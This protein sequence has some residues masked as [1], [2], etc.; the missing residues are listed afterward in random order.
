MDQSV[1]RD[2][3]FARR[4]VGELVGPYRL[5]QVLGVGGMAAV[6]LGR[7]HDG[8]VA[9]IK[10]L[11]PAMSVRP[12]VRERFYR[13]GYVANSIQHPGVVRVLSHGEAQHAYLAMELLSGETLSERARRLGQLPLPE[14]LAL[15][16]QVLDVLCVAHERGIVHRDLKPDNLFVTSAN[17]IKILDFGLARLS[18]SA[19]SEHRTRTGVALG[20]LP[21]MAPEQALGRLSEIDG[22]V[23]LFALGATLF[24]ILT[25]RRVHEGNSVAELLIAMASK[26]APPLASVRPDLPSELCRVVD[27]AL[28]FSRDARYPDARTM[29]GDVRALRQGAPPPYASARFSQREQKT[30]ADLAL[31]GAP[32]SFGPK[33]TVPIAIHRGAP[34]G[35]TV[36]SA[37]ATPPFAAGAAAPDFAAQPA[38]FAATVLV[39]SPTPP[40]SAAAAFSA[41][42]YGHTPANA[43]LGATYPAAGAAAQL[44]Q[45]PAA[46]FAGSTALPPSAP[47]AQDSASTRRGL[48]IALGLIGVC[49]MCGVVAAIF[50]ALRARSAPTA[51][52]QASAASG[53][54]SA[55][56]AAASPPKAASSAALAPALPAATS[57]APATAARGAAASPPRPTSSTRP[58][59]GRG[60][61]R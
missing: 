31:D 60:K 52:E 11:H 12:D 58:A 34:L 46:A 48:L 3:L 24:R 25:G 2:E 21:Y 6:Y 23:D 57:S 38:A 36:P 17:T 18:E 4:R 13:E 7:A 15:A 56:A 35:Q 49:V 33:G 45:T 8:S 16:E 50:W 55:V 1:E 39:A 40:A 32:L 22:R 10:L 44:A 27:L 51:A 47:L 59:R 29:L 43:A 9:A 54:D 14:L 61:R 5:E 53:A 28:A 20:T 42:A 19:P 30:R 37:T 26:P 41:A